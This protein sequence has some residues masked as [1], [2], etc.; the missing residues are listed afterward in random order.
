MDFA[1]ICVCLLL[2]HLFKMSRLNFN[3]IW[4]KLPALV[5]YLANCLERMSSCLHL[6]AVDRWR[7]LNLV[8]HE[9]SELRLVCRI[10]K[11]TT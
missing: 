8:G 9:Y 4:S 10:R 2:N 6:G 7:M 1:S 3:S 5:T 11:I